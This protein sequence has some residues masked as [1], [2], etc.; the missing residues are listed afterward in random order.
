MRWRTLR[1]SQRFDQK[2]YNEP[3][4]NRIPDFIVFSETV[5]KGLS[6]H[7]WIAILI[8]G[9]VKGAR[10]SP[11]KWDV[12][13]LKQYWILSIGASV[14]LYATPISSICLVR[15]TTVFSSSSIWFSN[16]ARSCAVMPDR[17]EPSLSRLRVSASSSGSSLVFFP[18]L[19]LHTHI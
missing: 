12:L 5:Y 16:P 10:T 15:S 3:K 4:I 13:T 11:S 7:I 9:P 2:R 19:I 17:D 6:R 1:K 18:C 8:L 14:E